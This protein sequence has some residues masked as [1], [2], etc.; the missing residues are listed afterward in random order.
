MQ[1]E[2]S[3][4]LYPL[5]RIRLTPV[6]H[7]C[8]PRKH[9]WDHHCILRH[10]CGSA[11]TLSLRAK[12]PRPAVALTQIYGLNS[13]TGPFSQ[14]FWTH[15]YLMPYQKKK[16]DLLNPIVTHIIYWHLKKQQEHQNQFSWTAKMH[17]CWLSVNYN[18]SCLTLGTWNCTHI[19]QCCSSNTTGTL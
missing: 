7:L 15:L 16:Q 10:L 12:V 17:T 4:V 18:G 11:H 3:L 19:K 13:S 9:L 6:N 2:W 1:L 14:K 5:L 8:C